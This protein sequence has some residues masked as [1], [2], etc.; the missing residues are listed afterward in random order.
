MSLQVPTRVT[1]ALY[2]CICACLTFCLFFSN[3]GALARAADGL[4]PELSGK[5]LIHPAS[6][7]WQ[8]AADKITYDQNTKTYEAEGNVRIWSD[9]R[10]MQAAW[11]RLDTQEQE[12]ELKGNVLLQYGKNW[13]KGEH[14]VWKLEKEIGYVDGG[15]IYF[16]ENH[17]YAQGEY[18]AKTGPKE[19]ELREGFLTTCD[20]VKSDWKIKYRQMTVRLD[21]TA[22][23]NHTSFWI[24]DLP[25]LYTPYVALPVQLTRQSG[26]LLPWAGYSELNGFQGELPYYWAMR[27]DMDA[28]LYGRYMEERGWMSGLEYRIANNTWG[29]GIWLANYLDDQADEGFQDSVGY[30]LQTRDRY[31]V[32]SRHNFELPYE[33]TGRLDLDLASD[34]FFLREFEKGSSS[35][36]YSNA[37]FR[38]YTGRGIL[39]DETTLV[40]ESTLYLERGY[41]SSLL[42]MDVRYWDQ[43]N[44]SV[45]ELTLQ[46]LPMF[47]FNVIPDWVDDLPIY[48]TLDSSFTNYWR[49][50]GDRG[51]RLNLQP[52]LYYPLHWKSYLDIEPSAGF[53]ATSYW[54]DWDGDSHDPWQGRFLTDMQL[55][56]S[57]RLNRVYPMEMGDYVA[58]QHAIRPQIVYE[59]VPEGI[60]DTVPHFD[61]LDDDLARHDVRYGVTTFLTTKEMK[62]DAEGNPTADYREVARMELFQAYNIEASEQDFPDDIRLNPGREEGFSDFGLRLDLMPKRYV[63][64][65]YDTDFS[66]E[67]VQ[68][69]RQ[70]VYVTLDSGKGHLFRLDYQY[71]R[72]SFVD[73]IIP[74]VS[75]KVL[76]NIYVNS[77]HDYSFDQDELFAQGYGLRYES[78][79][80]AIGVVYERED[81]DQRVAVTLNLLGIGSLRGSQFFRTENGLN[82]MP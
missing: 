47:S 29:K 7:T 17:F 18:I 80:W 50:E 52:R 76:P 75:L 16:A 60:E 40:R 45:D 22:T 39:N 9:D 23:A 24:R 19:Y 59:Y 61:R 30:P 53:R 72:D 64:L 31:W 20:P 70:D 8:I 63:T 57:S 58:A 44:K 26:F 56:L 12:A 65:S 5:S 78:G 81:E 13:L 6:G 37:M 77:Y 82:G 49:R 38:E 41:E 10:S 51:S 34:R 74:Q 48:Y 33:I 69:T 42:S 68:T 15:L 1:T 54:V 55:A 66:S 36:D 73:E 11:A 4:E 3:L 67:E 62:R 79:C 14:V 28:T 27:E 2:L 21:G 71:R 32:R 43:L 35:Y 46:R 25:V